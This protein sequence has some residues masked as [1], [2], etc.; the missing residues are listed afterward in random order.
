MRSHS[1]GGTVVHAPKL[2]R[3]EVE[4]ALAT[5]RNSATVCGGGVSGLCGDHF[6]FCSVRSFLLSIARTEHRDLG[7]QE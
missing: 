5:R 4:R 1:A 2:L 7:G 6:T 3:E